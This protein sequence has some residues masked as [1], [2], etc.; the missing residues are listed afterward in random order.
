MDQQTLQILQSFEARLQGVEKVTIENNAV[1]TDINKSL[2]IA[3]Y[4]QIGYILLFA[5]GGLAAYTIMKPMLSNALAT[6]NSLSQ[7]L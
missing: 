4:I 6:F 7:I 3:R 1:M 2:K 5:G